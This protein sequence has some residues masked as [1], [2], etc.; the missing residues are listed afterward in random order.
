[1]TKTKKSD[2]GDA[3]VPED[4]PPAGLRECTI[5]RGPFD[6]DAEGGTEGFIG[7]LP[8]AFCP[9]CKC[10]ILDFAESYQPGFDCPHCQMYIERE[11]EPTH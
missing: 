4:R 10:G 1:M 9:T 11:Y 3:R 6:I 7:I 2:K 8:V 5:C